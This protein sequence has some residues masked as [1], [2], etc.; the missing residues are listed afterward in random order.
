[1]IHTTQC[2]LRVASTVVISVFLLSTV[3]PVTA[4]DSPDDHVKLPPAAVGKVHFHRQ[5][6]PILAR[7]CMKC[8]GQG[9]AK[10][11]FRIDSR[12]TMLEWGES[13][14][15]VHIG[16]SAESLLIQ[17]V[18]GIDADR[19]MPRQGPKWTPEQFG[20]LR[21]WIDRGREWEVSRPFA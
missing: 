21:A 2:H 17:L 14:P 16:K 12:E 11:G 10:G 7:S 6:A 8:H 13:G 20:L 5:I 15:A 4:G 18:A 9:K 19:I 3:A 1:M